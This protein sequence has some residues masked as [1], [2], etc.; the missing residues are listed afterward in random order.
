LNRRGIAWF[1][2]LGID[3]RD[4]A[5]QRRAFCR[6]CMDWSERRQHLAGALGAAILARIFELRWAKRLAGSRVVKFSATGE[7]AFLNLL[8]TTGNQARG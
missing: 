5:T 1:Q 7:K 8:Q 4:I 6:P 3:T 2:R